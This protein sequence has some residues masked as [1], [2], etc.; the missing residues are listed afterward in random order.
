[1]KA[2]KMI[3]DLRSQLIEIENLFEEAL[4]QDSVEDR[5]VSKFYKQTKSLG[6]IQL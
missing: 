5:Q 6:K 3:E 1:M 4:D 2:N